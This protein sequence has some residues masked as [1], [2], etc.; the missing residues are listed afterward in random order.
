[1]LFIPGIE[2][3]CSANLSNVMHHMHR[4]AGWIGREVCSKLR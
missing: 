2:R 4:G 3:L 1:M